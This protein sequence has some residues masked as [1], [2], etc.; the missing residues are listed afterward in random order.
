VRINPWA[1][2]FIL[3]L[4]RMALGF[5]FQSVVSIAPDLMDVFK[6]DYTAIGTLVGLFTFPGLV[7]SLLAGVMGKRFG[8][9]R[10]VSAG[11]LLMLSG[12]VCMALSSSFLVLSVGRLQCGIGAI[13]L[14]VLLTKMVADWFAGKQLSLAM[15]VII[16]GW[17]MG[18]GVGL[19]THHLIADALTWRGVFWANAVFAGTVLL[20]MLVFY[21]NPQIAGQG[22][23]AAGS[24]ISRSEVVRVS[25]AAIGLTLYNAAVVMILSF[26]P[27]L[28]IADGAGSLVAGSLVNGHILISIVGVAL[29][30]ILASKKSRFLTIGAAL[31]FCAAVLFY[32]ALGQTHNV[33]F[34]AMGLFIGMPVALLMTLPA[35]VLA[36]AN[37]DVGFGILYTWVYGGLALL[38]VLAGYLRTVYQTPSAPVILAGVLLALT[39]LSTWLF[40][41]ISQP[42]PGDTQVDAV[43]AK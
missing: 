36:P 34:L 23:I 24:R 30:G 1:A 27:G 21:R 12:S 7:F 35:T 32:Q 31:F 8:N 39:P 5:Q 42:A 18:I 2:L 37:R 16:N 17:P 13:V 11:L 9:K 22:A 10:A 25:F 28:F 19:L 4:G 40:V 6:V 26:V 15:S 41:V 38:M 14:F 3:F 43:P 33:L 20:A 29:G